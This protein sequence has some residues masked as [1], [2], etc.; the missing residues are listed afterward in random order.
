MSFQPRIRGSGCGRVGD[1]G[2]FPQRSRAVCVE[3]RRPPGARE[4]D[5]QEIFSPSVSEPFR[6]GAAARL[7]SF[8][9]SSKPLGTLAMP[10]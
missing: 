10:T 7:G 9:V 5:I 8:E 6:F 4:A 1:V 2:E 3:S